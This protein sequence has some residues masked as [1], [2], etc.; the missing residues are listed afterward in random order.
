MTLL[1]WGV[2]VYQN[3]RGLGRSGNTSPQ[4]KQVRDFG[5]QT[6]GI[7]ESPGPRSPR[8]AI[9]R[10]ASSRHAGATD[11]LP[12][13]IPVPQVLFLSSFPVETKGHQPGH[14]RDTCGASVQDT[15]GASRYNRWD[16][17]GTAKVGWSNR[18][19]FRLNPQTRRM[20]SG[21]L[22]KRTPR[23]SWGYAY[24][25]HSLPQPSTW[26]A[27]IQVRNSP[28]TTACA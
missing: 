6:P 27:H 8:S 24:R 9:A 14:H 5:I 4:Q 11:V 23:S 20:M 2:R 16:T 15:G 21:T 18:T 22:H 10:P 19:R 7:H 25:A 13:S 28:S 12:T 17:T 26:L 1:G 3:S